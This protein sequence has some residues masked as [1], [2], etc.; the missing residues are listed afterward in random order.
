MI[1]VEG[2]C[3]RFSSSIQVHTPPGKSVSVRDTVFL[4]V[5]LSTCSFGVVCL[6]GPE[7]PESSRSY[8]AS[9]ASTR[10]SPN[11]LPELGESVAWC[12]AL[13]CLRVSLVKSLGE[14]SERSAYTNGIHI[15][16]VMSAYDDE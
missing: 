10:S 4:Y 11:R 2:L 13:T 7:E 16:L 1:H 3:R 8:E 9:R 14:I 15:R 6:S 5:C 12:L